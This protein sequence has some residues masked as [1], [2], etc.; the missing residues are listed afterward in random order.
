MS[1]RSWLFVPGDSERKLAKADGAGADALIIDL[2]DSVADSNKAVARENIAA[3]LAARPAQARRSRIWVRINPLDRHALGDLAAIVAGAPDGIMLP[4]ADGPADVIRLSHYLDALETREALAPGAI[5]VLPVATET[6]VAPFAL[7]SYA[8][9]PL[10]RLAGLTWG[11]EDLAAALGASTNREPSGEFAFIYRWVRSATLLAA[12][13]AGVPAI[14][15]LHGDFRDTQGL[16]ATSRAAAREGFSG[17]IAIHPDQVTVI[18][19]AFAPSEQD[20]VFA[21]R[22]VAAFAEQ[23]GAGTIALDGK[24][25][26][27]PHLKQARQMLLTHDAILSRGSTKP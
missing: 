8:T 4:K 7:G 15:T 6:A 23:P 14:E 22:V 11:A 5:G 26:D 16:E 12:R 24:M 1:I 25:L 27:L 20:V 21:S 13:A 3:F 2:E 9:T 10:A 17:R 19:A 18:N